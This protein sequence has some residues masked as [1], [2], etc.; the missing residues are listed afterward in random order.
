MQYEMPLSQMNN[1][2]GIVI[3]HRLLFDQVVF[4]ISNEYIDYYY[5]WRLCFIFYDHKKTIKILEIFIIHHL[6]ERKW[7]P[8]SSIIPLI[9]INKMFL[10]YENIQRKE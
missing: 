7:F 2:L 1:I 3:I 10:P 6:I 5:V 4:I 9:T 8:S